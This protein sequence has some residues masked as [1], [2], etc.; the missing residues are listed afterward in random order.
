MKLETET[1]EIVVQNEL[2]FV[3]IKENAEF[4]LDNIKKDR[5]LTYN[6]IGSE[7]LPVL[8]DASEHFFITPEGQEF[9][10]SEVANV[11]RRSVAYYAPT[12]SSFIKLR[13]FKTF[14]QPTVPSEV[15][16]RKE[17]ALNWLKSF[18]DKK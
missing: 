2:L 15:F 11:N 9:A 3:K 13:H 10:A 8:V 6:L 5:E 16:T 14:N 12:L 18:L 17:K 1:V 4:T 7:K